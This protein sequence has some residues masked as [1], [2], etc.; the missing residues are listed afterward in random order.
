[1]TFYLNFRCQGVGGGV[2]DP[3]VLQGDG[4]TTPPSLTAMEWGAVGPLVAGKNVLFATH[5]FN[6]SYEAGACSLAQLEP[7][8]HLG[9]SDIYFGVLWPGDFWIPVVNY[10]FEGDVAI[11]CG[12]RLADF[13][14]R[15]LGRAQSL[16]FVSHSLGARLVLEA[17]KQLD[18]PAR[19]VCL[20]A[21][22][23]NH[24]CL[25]T[26][27]DKA[28][29]KATSVSLLASHSDLVLKIAFAIGD[30]ISDVLHDDHPIFEPALGYAG[31]PTPAPPP[32]ASPWQIPDL[33]DYGHGNYLPPGDTVQTAAEI[34]L[35]KW[36]RV[37]GF[38]E[39]AY[40][41]RPQ[42]WP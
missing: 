37:A 35:D 38:V 29:S 39:R 20:L 28:R 15:W 23:I 5:G 1:M 24:D 11:D 12:R 2:V 40:K 25:T 8:L 6:V 3:Y 19:S 18:G 13:C 30:P 27:Y 31:P 26:E 16:S 42:T 7:Q 17:V 34:E 9:A 10:P 41:G 14:K 21:G 4:T 36:C 33:L 32:V 22:A